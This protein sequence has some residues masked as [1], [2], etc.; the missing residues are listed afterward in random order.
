MSLSFAFRPI[1]R[2]LILPLLVVLAVP[3]FS[4]SSSHAQQAPA[5]TGAGELEFDGRSDFSHI[6][7][8]R[9]GALRSML[10]VRDSGE[11]VLESQIN[12]RQPHVLQFEYLQNLARRRIERRERLA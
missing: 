10:F 11:E 12:L 3:I 6:R 5:V 2:R 1:G 7:I 9:N 4:A 8:R